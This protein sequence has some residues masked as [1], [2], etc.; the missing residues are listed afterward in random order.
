LFYYSKPIIITTCNNNNGIMSILLRSSLI[1]IPR[2]QA[3]TLALPRTY[4]TSSSST[5]TPPKPST[6]TRITT[7]NDDGLV[8][9]NRLSTREKAARSTQQSFNFI[10]IIAGVLMTGAVSYILY[11]EVFSPTSKTSQFNYAV[12]RIKDSPECVRLLCG[13]HGRAK[14][15]KAYGEGSNWNRWDRNRTIAGSTTVD[16]LG[17]ENWHI[18]FNVEGPVGRGVV[19]VHLVRGPQGGEWEYKVLALD[20]PG[21]HRVWLENMDKKFG[22]DKKSGTMFGIK[23][24]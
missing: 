3:L 24:W 15:I 10:V 22:V 14:E 23:W 4:A 12:S 1:H 5:N 2:R 17:V 9:W 21:H 16:R 13:P 6:H 11:K 19:R 7:F 8:N 20:V 18:H